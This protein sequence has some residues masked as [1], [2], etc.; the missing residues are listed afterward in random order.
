MSP[1][2]IDSLETPNLGRRPAIALALYMTQDEVLLSWCSLR[3]PVL[4]QKSIIHFIEANPAG[5]AL[6]GT[7][8]PIR[9]LAENVVEAA[10]LGGGGETGSGLLNVDVDDVIGAGGRGL[11]GAGVLVDSYGDFG[12][13]D[14]LAD[15][16]ADALE[17][18]SRLW[19][20]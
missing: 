12:E 5:L 7:K 17:S 16:E 8:E 14:A 9:V 15:E 3:D 4:L 18:E 6:D 20:V 10:Q 2:A 1:L 19:R 11:G 13:T